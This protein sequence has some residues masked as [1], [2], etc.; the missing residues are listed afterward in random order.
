MFMFLFVHRDA[1][2]GFP[3]FPFFF[4]FRVVFLFACFF[5]LRSIGKNWSKIKI[6]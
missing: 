3:L 1:K 6:V 5:L 4:A 2:D